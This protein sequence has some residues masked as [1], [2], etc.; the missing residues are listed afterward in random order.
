MTRTIDDITICNFMKTTE[1]IPK[2]K[3][4]LQGSDKQ[5]YIYEGRQSK[6]IG[7][8]VPGDW[9]NLRKKNMKIAED[10]DKKMMARAE[11]FWAKDPYILTT[12]YYIAIWKDDDIIITNKYED[13]T[14]KKGEITK[15]V[16]IGFVRLELQQLLVV[17]VKLGINRIP[18]EWRSEKP[19]NFFSRSVSVKKLNEN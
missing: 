8:T 14:I 17:L 9:W 3:Q 5:D 12:V 16:N 10:E 11:K 15:L 6:P 13:C 1:L 2:A 7:R 4:L 18:K 19:G